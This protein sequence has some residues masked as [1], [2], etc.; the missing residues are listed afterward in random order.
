M[1]WEVNRRAMDSAALVPLIAALDALYCLANVPL[2]LAFRVEW[3]GGL[4]SGAGLAPFDERAARR[5]ALR[6]M[7]TGGRKGGPSPKA[8]LS[9]LRRARP[10]LSASVTLSLGDAAATALLCGALNALGGALRGVSLNAT[11]DFGG[12]LAFC[13]QGM[14]T[15]R[16]GHIMAAAT[17]YGVKQIIRRM[18]AWTS[19]PSRAS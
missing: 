6:A 12:S 15:A 1:L 7:G 3:R 18:K 4:R 11:P 13:A 5:K 16:A 8:I 19:T 9:I 17:R 10:A 2:C 14:V